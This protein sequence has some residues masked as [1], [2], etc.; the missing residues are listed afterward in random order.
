[1]TNLETQNLPELDKSRERLELIGN[2]I[3][4]FRNSY[5]FSQGN[6]TLQHLLFTLVRDHYAQASPEIVEQIPAALLA[7]SQNIG[8][9]VLPSRHRQIDSAKVTEDYN[10]MFTEFTSYL[11]E[12]GY[13]S[14]SEDARYY[15]RQANVMGS[16]PEEH[17]VRIVMLLDKLS[18]QDPQF[19]DRGGKNRLSGRTMGGDSIEARYES[20]LR[21]Y[22][23]EGK[24]TF[25]DAYNAIF[26]DARKV[27]L[28]THP[29]TGLEG[30]VDD[31]EAHHPGEAFYPES[32]LE[33]AAAQ[34]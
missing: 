25:S 20:Y 34:S 16:F 17:E 22:V 10:K 3:R 27:L 18:Q 33:E 9:F 23:I 7:V 19:L 15:D 8:R 29:D 1:M 26:A 4:D 2:L 30:L 28:A 11:T 21:T 13:V 5:R 24:D 6:P 14:E 12:P 31:W 32:F